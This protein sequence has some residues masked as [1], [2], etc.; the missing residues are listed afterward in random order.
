VRIRWLRRSLAFLVVAGGVLAATPTHACDCRRLPEPSPAVASEA[1]F[2]FAGR[3]VEIRERSEHLSITRD[4]AAETSVRPL[5]RL[6]VFRVAKAWRGVTAPTFTVATDWSDCSYPFAVGL[7]YLVFANAQGRARPST[8][9]CARTTPLDRGGRL[10][11]LLG[12]PR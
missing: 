9:I 6:V 1:S 3:V 4:G 12:S 11:E 7:D 8:S 2:V 5:D 10:L